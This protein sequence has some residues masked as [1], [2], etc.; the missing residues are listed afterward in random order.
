MLDLEE[1]FPSFTLA[2]EDGSMVSSRDLRG[3][4]HLVFFVPKAG[5]RASRRQLVGF[6]DAWAEIQNAGLTVY[7]VTYDS[8]AENRQLIR[9]ERLPFSLLADRGKILAEDAEARAGFLNFPLRISFLMAAD[10]TLK[11][12]YLVSKPSSHAFDV[13]ADLA[14]LDLRRA[15]LAS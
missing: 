15:R 13:L 4:P 8:P 12:I 3:A 5:S 14:A 11:K 10:G 7:A 9:A 2:A 6:R 1:P